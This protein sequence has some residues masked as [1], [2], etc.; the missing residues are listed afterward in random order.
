VKGY[1]NTVHNATGMAPARIADKSILAIWQRLHKKESRVRSVE[2]K[3]RVGQLVRI[4]K[5]KAKFRNSKVHSQLVLHF[6]R[7]PTLSYI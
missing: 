5:E 1:N 4:S 3:Y 7:V 2:A 6:R